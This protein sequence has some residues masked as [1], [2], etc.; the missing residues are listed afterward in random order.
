MRPNE[1]RSL[2][3]LQDVPGCQASP[4]APSPKAS[5]P[6]AHGVAA[7]DGLPLDQ[8]GYPGQTDLGR[9]LHIAEQLSRV[10]AAIHARGVI[11]MDINPAHILIR[12]DD[13]ALQV[14]GFGLATTFIEEPVV[15]DHRHPIL[16][17]PAFMSPEQ[18]GQM[19]R[20]V[21][22]RTDL[23]SLGATLYL[24]ATG[25]PPFALTDKL[26]LLHAHL[27]ISPQPPQI[28]APWLPGTVS[29]LILTLLEKEPAD[30]YQSAAGLVH[31]IQQLRSA[32]AEGRPLDSVPLRQRDMPLFPR[33]GRHLYGRDREVATLLDAVSATRR[34]GVQVVFV[35]G[36]S[37]VGKTCLIHE[38]ARPVGIGQGLF[39][40]GKFE[41]FQRDRPFLAPAQSILQ[42]CHLLLAKPEAKLDAWRQRIAAS[43]GPD[44]A[45][46]FDLVPDLA[47]LLGPQPPA[48]ALG[49]L[50]TRTRLRA[51]LLRLIRAVASPER[52]LVLFLDDLQ[53]A[54]EP[55]LD[56]IAALLEEPGADG[57]LLIGAFRDNEVDAAHPLYR[58]LRR[59]M[60]S[61]Q[62]PALL[63]LGNLAEPQLAD[64][65]A[66][67]LHM[68]AAAV[69][70]LAATLHARTD[71]NPFFALEFLNALYRDGLLTPDLERC[72][73]RWD[74]AAIL[75]YEASQN[76]VEFLVAGLATLSDAA[77]DV[78]VAAACL[79]NAF[80]LGLLARATETTPEDLADRLMPALER[81]ILLT[82]RAQAIH[83]ADPTTPL[84][85]C[86][87]RMQQ[88]IYQR[89]DDAWRAALHLAIA[90]R[91]ADSTDDTAPPFGA[92]EH[93]AQAASL[94][95][96][97]AEQRRARGL[98]LAAAT[99]AR[100]A[101]SFATAERFLRLAIGLLGPPPWL[102]DPAQAFRL[103]VEL[104]QVLYSQ[105]LYD[106]ADGLYAMLLRETASPEAL[107]DP[108][109]TQVASLSNRTRFG[110]ALR[111]GG[112]LLERLGIAMPAAALGVCI[113]DELR[114]F[115]QAVESGALDRLPSSR[116]M[117]D[118]AL[119]G[120]AKL[121]NRLEPCA[122]FSDEPRFGAWF[123]LRNIRLAIDHGPSD[124]VIFPLADVIGATVM[125]RDDY[126]TGCRAGRIALAMVQAGE[127]SVEQARALYI[128]A[129]AV[130]HW[131]Q[132]LSESIRHAQTAF[133]SLVRGGDLEF[134]CYSYFTTQAAVL[135]SC[136][137]LDDMKAEIAA[138]FTFAQ[139]TGNRSGEEAY[140][141]F[142]QLVR[143]LEG[144]TAQPG[145]F[146][147]DA[148]DEQAHLRAAQGN[149]MAI[150]YFHIYRALAAAIFGDSAALIDHADAARA[151]EP[152]VIGMYPVALITFLHTLALA[153][154][155]AATG[156]AGRLKLLDQLR[157]AE[158][159]LAA[160]AVEAPMNFS[161]L[162][163][164][165]QAERLDAT[166][167][168]WHAAQAFEQAMRA[169]QAHQ[170]PWHHALITEHAGRFHMRHG[171]EH[172]GRAL[173]LRAHNLYR[174][175]GALGKARAM[176]GAWPFL[177][178]HGADAARDR[179]DG[180]L[181]HEALLRASQ[182]LTSETS[183]AMLVARFVELVGQLSGATDAWLLLLDETGQWHVESVW[184]DGRI[185]TPARLSL[186]DA[187]A[188]QLIPSAALRL[189]LK[190]MAL[191]VSDDAVIDSRFKT[192]PHF[193]GRRLCSLLALP[194]L[195]QGRAT[196]FLVLENNLYR[197][198]F[199]AAQ[200][201]T[202]S[203]LCG[204][205]AVSLENARLYQSLER[206]VEARTHDLAVAN[207]KLR[208]LTETDMLTGIANRRKFETVWAEA[209]ETARH[210]RRPLSVAIVDVDHFKAYNDHYGHP[211]GDA[212]LRHVAQLLL[213]ALR[214]G[215]DFVA[216]LGGEEFVVVQP[217][218]PAAEAPQV[219]ERLR[220]AVQDGGI[221]HQRNET[222]A[223]VTVSI[224]V[225]SCTPTDACRPQDVLSAA[226]AALYQ[227]KRTGRNRWS[228]ATGPIA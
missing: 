173:L 179:R 24:L 228:S 222:A 63:T 118:P 48:P 156:D 209:W 218:L 205:L 75:R 67:R 112:A 221:L 171:L 86:H 111:L 203:F 214:P 107:V 99:H 22:Y 151:L 72:R 54:D 154:R 47:L 185:T 92:A 18:T 130:S 150:C 70:S 131:C 191:V 126:A 82:H 178:L 105:S 134:G 120:A 137:D 121:M 44:A 192:D 28:L 127:R 216:R 223:V 101:G 4:N 162:H 135:D 33:P 220:Q 71:G 152:W 136:A 224:G 215:L 139:R 144:L 102:D 41:Q 183:P 53:W 163:R 188:A 217:G 109:C 155:L 46:L 123:G 207:A 1:R 3:R 206:K 45:A 174:H 95:A 17:T 11:H 219:A 210:H 195:L 187:E 141:P 122:Y 76:V 129:A 13:G 2:G 94:I 170:R 74:K 68:S 204:Q 193:V 38:V 62:R 98:F 211:A 165:V 60:A 19:N 21:D 32:L 175:W 117:T 125:G 164:L 81:G 23:Y 189:A 34:G 64:L 225:A 145:R 39:I 146:D 153:A 15:F 31:D 167:Q 80:T 69:E 196:A 200:I 29:A 133:D 30:R 77:T 26:G 49:P 180:S 9:F 20:P 194:V 181:D 84:R 59:P 85:F 57:L 93:Y 113:E 87:D 226:D 166:G 115:Y 58:L 52:P 40:T 79:G 55:S 227:A 96:P 186:A 202:V 184:Q 78:L 149:R 42:L 37:G 114:L 138:A 172:A 213:G 91:F 140:L 108:T 51:Q 106:E 83:Q 158:A 50:E 103:H 16:G 169:A 132:P 7:F 8:S 110:D 147:D 10:I 182:A 6:D 116:P 190:T 168:P 124:A 97:G 43:I 56:F 161:H 176:Q 66:D 35:A 208:H 36:Y 104:H 65:L 157:G 25:R 73:W 160:R 61:G 148:F 89:R 90:R 143:S 198:A 88:A 177:A 197:A 119:L 142:R 5:L 27:A 199:S 159:W 128:F 14:V 212:C 12:P 100:Q 201:E